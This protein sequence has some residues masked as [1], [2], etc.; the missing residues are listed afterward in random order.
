MEKT[1]FSRR[2]AV[3]FA[4][5]FLT[6]FSR[7]QVAKHH[8][9]DEFIKIRVGFNS[10]N[11]FHRQLLLGFMD[12]LATA[13]FDPGYDAVQIDNQPSDLFFVLGDYRL[14]IQGVG[15]F[16]TGSVFPLEVKTAIPGTIGFTLDDTENLA[17]NIPVYIHDGLTNQYHNL[18]DGNLELFLP[19]GT[20]SNRFSLRFAMSLLLST[21]LADAGD[22]IV[23]RFANREHIL[24]IRNNSPSNAINSIE[25]YDVQGQRLTSWIVRDQLQEQFPLTQVLSNGTYLIKVQSDSGEVAKKILVENE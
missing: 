23:V 21:Q 1:T 22:G 19:A 24:N 3:T 9:D 17:A 25:V 20:V 14:V 12:D 10:A 15:H 2:K 13:D 18:R 6:T 11:G 8:G 4:C 5:L 16:E 7:A